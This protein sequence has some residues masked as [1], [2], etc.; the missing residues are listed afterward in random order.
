MGNIK[1]KFMVNK[2]IYYRNNWGVLSG[3]V[4]KS[5]KPLDDVITIVGGMPGPIQDEIYNATVV[6]KSNANYGKQYEIKSISLDVNITQEKDKRDFLL[7]LYTE[8][9]VQAMYD[10]LSDPFATLKNKDV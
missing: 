1:L 8:N 4:L 9:Q 5:N 7:R 2:V 3:T 6:E 10:S